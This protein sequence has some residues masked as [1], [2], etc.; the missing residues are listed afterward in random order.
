[1]QIDNSNWIAAQTY[2]RHQVP[3]PDFYPWNQ[4][5]DAGG[6]PIYP[7]RERLLGPQFAK[8]AAGTVFDG[9]FDGKMIVVENLSDAAAWPW[10]A[11][12][13]RKAVTRHLGPKTD[14]N[15]RL[16]YTQYAAHGGGNGPELVTFTGVL[17]Q[18]LL[19]VSDW[20]EKGIAP[21]PT[22]NYKIVE[23]QVIV[24][25]TAAER[26]GIQPVVALRANGG[27]RA[28]VAVGQS[29]SF[30]ATIT[31]PR[32]AGK[33]VSA[34]WDFE[35]VGTFPVPARL[36][37]AASGGALVRASYSFTKP[38]TYFAVLRAASQRDGDPGTPYT[39]ILN[40]GRV[41]VIVR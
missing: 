4:F 12:W 8:G 22:T 38:G 14:A 7:Q 25:A 39:R 31:V 33:V 35:G 26:G 28:D 37:P 13:Y 3:T 11:D 34:E 16:W 20:V 24:P 21:A 2:H 15:F 19:D 1:V 36:V 27:L 23:S 9:K 32:G 29:V 40:L 10:N 6:K 30:S 41:R 18:A 17:Q 5:R